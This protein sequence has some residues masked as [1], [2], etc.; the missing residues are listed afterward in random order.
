MAL[1][2]TAHAEAGDPVPSLFSSTPVFQPPGNSSAPNVLPNKKHFHDGHS[3]WLLWFLY[4][5]EA[6]K[7]YTGNFWAL[8]CSQRI[9]E[10]TIFHNH[11]K[12]LAC[13][14]LISSWAVGRALQKPRDLRDT[15][16]W[17]QK[18]TR[19]PVFCKAGISEICKKYETPPFSLNV[20]C[21]NIVIFLKY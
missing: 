9:S 11:Q 13:F 16:D 20:F 14:T 4:I 6:L 5:T 12:L 7:V 21:L 15:A 8:R 17:P 3:R 18:Q 1:G 19:N 10:A 2:F